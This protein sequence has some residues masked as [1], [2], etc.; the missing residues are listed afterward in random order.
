MN[1]PERTL[2][3]GISL[4][5][6][7]GETAPNVN[8]T[9]SPSSCSLSNSDYAFTINFY[10]QPI[11]KKATSAGVTTT[12][13]ASQS[14]VSATMGKILLTGATSA[15]SLIKNSIKGS[16]PIIVK[17]AS[18]ATTTPYLGVLPVIESAAASNGVDAGSF[19]VPRYFPHGG[20]INTTLAGTV[21]DEDAE[22]NATTVTNAGVW[23]LKATCEYV[24]A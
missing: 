9:L 23:E 10:A 16:A 18:S 1:V 8:A 4:F 19:F 3:T 5:S 21:A 12:T 22:V 2:V 11:T 14:S 13:Y 6:V 7:P 17:A 20:R 24:P 15:G